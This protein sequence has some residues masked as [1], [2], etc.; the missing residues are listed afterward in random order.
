MIRDQATRLRQSL[1]EVT[2]L[3][4]REREVFPDVI[5][6]SAA[7]IT[8]ACDRVER[9]ARDLR[10]AAVESEWRRRDAG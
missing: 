10:V 3:L 1:A 9:A 4:A 2:D 8:D 5:A 6:P 7:E